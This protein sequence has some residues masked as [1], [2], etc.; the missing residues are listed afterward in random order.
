MSVNRSR[1]IKPLLIVDGETPMADVGALNTFAGVIMDIGCASEMLPGLAG[2]AGRSFTL[3]ARAESIGQINEDTLIRLVGAGIDGVV[4]AGCRG[5]SD[6]Q[7]LD[8]M[9]RVAEAVSGSAP[10]RIKIYAEYGGSPEGLLSP[11]GLAEASARLEALIFN[12]AALAKSTGCK[13]PTVTAHE[14]VA[15]PI[16]MARAAVVLRAGEAGLAAYEVL[17]ANIDE[18]ATR[19]ALSQS[20]DDGFASVVFHSI[21]QAE[22]AGGA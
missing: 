1:T 9:L 5:R 10:N 7:R 16:L 8:V 12:G 17:P 22:M 20:R 2:S 19:R 14:R 6:I 21:Q 11:H 3:L 4:L 13:A 18:A 15:A